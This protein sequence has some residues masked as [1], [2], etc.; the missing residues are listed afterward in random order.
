MVVSTLSHLPQCRT[1]IGLQPLRWILV[2]R[3]NPPAAELAPNN[4]GRPGRRWWLSRYALSRVL[5]DRAG[6]TLKIM[7]VNGHS[8]VYWIKKSLVLS[9][10]GML[11]EMFATLGLDGEGASE[12][13]AI[14]LNVTP[15]DFEMLVHYY[16]DFEFVIPQSSSSLV[17]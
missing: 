11:C 10:P 15:E 12:E 8:K 9:E 13:Q 2:N 3:A 7:Q 4:I 6:L 1:G 14:K 5:A 16:N 17:S